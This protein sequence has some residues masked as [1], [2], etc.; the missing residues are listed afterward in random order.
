MRIIKKI[1]LFIFAVLIVG[2][3]AAAFMK[4]DFAVEKQVVINLPKDSVFKFIKYAKNQEKYS[5]W[6]KMDPNMKK[7]ES[8][9]DGTVGFV[10]GWE[11]TNKNVGVGEMEIKNIIEGQRVDFELRFKEPMEA[12]NNAYLTTESITPNQTSVKWGFN[13]KS[14]YPFNLMM[15]FVDMDKVVGKDFQEGL[16]NL[17]IVLEKK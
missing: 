11:S 5:V 13:G 1:F 12:T 6:N 9:T 14:P 7:H 16:N 2:L 17:K 10:T 15:A 4:K 3:V 8:G